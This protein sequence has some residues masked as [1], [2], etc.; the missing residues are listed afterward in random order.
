M[1][2]TGK[3]E[4]RDQSGIDTSYILSVIPLSLYEA[5]QLAAL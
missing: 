3:Q 4:D 2:V 1:T 5:G